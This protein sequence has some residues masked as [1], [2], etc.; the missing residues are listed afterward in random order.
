MRGVKSEH[1]S[2]YVSSLLLMVAA[3]LESVARVKA[4]FLPGRV[5]S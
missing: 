4:G 5:A 1:T 2:I 3:M